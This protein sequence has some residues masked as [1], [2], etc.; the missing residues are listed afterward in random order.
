MVYFSRVGV[1]KLTVSQAVFQVAE[2]QVAMKR[3]G[4]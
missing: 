4:G 2:D 1:R 3:R